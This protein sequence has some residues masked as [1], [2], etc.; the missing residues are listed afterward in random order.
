MSTAVHAAK[1]KQLALILLH[2]RDQTPGTRQTVER[3]WQAAIDKAAAKG[4]I[5]PLVPRPSRKFF[6]YA[7]MLDS[8]QG[9]ALDFGSEAL[10]AAGWKFFQ[11][12]RD[13]LLS[14]ASQTP[15]ALQR[16][17]VD[18]FLTDT[19]KYLGNGRVAC[20]VDDGL[21]ALWHT[22]PDGAPIVAI[23]HSMGSIVLYK[24]LMGQLK[25]NGH[26]VYLI[27]VG[28]MIAQADVQRA[29]LGSFASYPGPVPP[30]VVWWRN[31]VNQGDLLAFNAAAGF[32]TS[33]PAKRPVDVAIDTDAENRHL[34]TNYL[35]SEAMGRAI[36]E[37]ACYALALKKRCGPSDK[38]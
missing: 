2:G 4:G 7:D 20:G 32:Q 12:T 18:G 34:A 35:E 15:V 19:G 23:A 8:E 9:C 14:L 26:D 10:R 11:G 13:A 31:I 3:D 21:D 16:Q 1:K 36:A 37:A 17:L 29:V 28:S 30:S 25:S 38:N 24:N 6:W 27:T 22:V 5:A 33:F